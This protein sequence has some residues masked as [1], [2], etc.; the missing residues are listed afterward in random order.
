VETAFLGEDLALP[1]LERAGKA[2]WQDEYL[3]WL[4]DESARL[5]AKYVVWT[6]PRDY[7]LLYLKLLAG[8]PLDFLKILKDTGLL[9]GDGKPRKSFE[10]WEKWRALPVK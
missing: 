9:D 2:A 7:D 5:N 10:T 1:G 3:R 8:T 6:V 4:L